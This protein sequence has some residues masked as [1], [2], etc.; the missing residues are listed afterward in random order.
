[1]EWGHV[2]LACS[3]IHINILDNN[4]LIYIG[5]PAGVHHK[6]CWHHNTQTKDAVGSVMSQRSDCHSDNKNLRH[7]SVAGVCVRACVR[8][9]FFRFFFFYSTRVLTKRLHETRE[10]PR[11][12]RIKD[13]QWSR[14]WGEPIMSVTIERGWIHQPSDSVLLEW[15]DLGQGHKV[16]IIWVTTRWGVHTHRHE[17]ERNENWD[18]EKVTNTKLS[19]PVSEN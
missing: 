5:T 14:S 11:I 18:Q 10:L 1:M 2:H 6:A 3:K 17:L 9:Y 19:F 7:F 4:I 16:L 13:G 12:Q 15:G 8:A